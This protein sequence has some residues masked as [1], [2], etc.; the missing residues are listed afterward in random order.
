MA[1]RTCLL[2]RARRPINILRLLILPR[3]HTLHPIRIISRQTLILSR[4]RD[5]RSLR[6]LMD[7]QRRFTLNHRPDM[8]NKRLVMLSRH[9]V[10][11][12]NQ[13]PYTANRRRRML[14]RAVI[15]IRLLLP[16][17]YCRLLAEHPHQASRA[18]AFNLR[19]PGI[20]M[21]HPAQVPRP[22]LFCRK[23]HIFNT[24]NLPPLPWP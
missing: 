20:P 14:H 18:E 8:H 12:L 11:M 15:T 4:H 22:R 16:R 21:P 17:R 13:R 2:P 23:I 10:D 19:Q 3:P 24:V 7:S 1:G 9:L 6:P 5:I